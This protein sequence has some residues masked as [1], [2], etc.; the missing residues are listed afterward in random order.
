MA[1]EYADRKRLTFEQAEGA[2]PLPSQLKLKEVSP[3]LRA[4]LWSIFHQ[5][6]EYMRERSS[7]GPIN[8]LVGH[9]CM[10]L[11]DWHVVRCFKPAD[12]FLPSF[13]HWRAELKTLFGRATT[14]RFLASCNGCCGA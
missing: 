4:R 7:A 2:E 13:N 12:E 6:L 3:E 8:Q 14:L 10:I 11:Y 9:Y 5:L 1:S